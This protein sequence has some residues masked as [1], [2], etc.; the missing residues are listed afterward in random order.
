MTDSLVVVEIFEK[1]NEIQYISNI[2]PI[3]S[4]LI[5]AFIG[6]LF[7]YLIHRS[8]KK[9]K[10]LLSLVKEKFQ[11]SQTAF[12]YSIKFVS[13]IHGDEELKHSLLKEAKMWYNENNLY[14]HPSIRD[15]FES[16]I[17]KLFMYENT[18]ALFYQ[19]K[20][21]NNKDKAEEQNVKL[22]KDF[23]DI[24]SLNNRIQENIDSYY[25][26]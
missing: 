7:T 23:N 19:F 8:D 12:N 13:I 2:T 1:L 6:W 20:N 14:L 16:T 18:L 22:K 10:F 15:D 3:I 24:I 26:K 11:A 25:K 17:N 9:D 4:I 5:V 21:S